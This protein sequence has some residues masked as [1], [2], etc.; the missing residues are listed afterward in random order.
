[1]GGS[2]EVRFDPLEDQ[3]L[4]DRCLA[5]DATAW[6]RLV[7]RHERLVFA[8]ARSYRLADSDLADVFQEVFAALVNGLPRLREPR[9]LVRWLS[10]TAQRIA[11]ATAL[12]RR[13]EQALWAGHPEEMPIPGPDEPVEA[14]LERIEEQAMVRLALTALPPRCQRLLLALYY[15]DP[16]PAYADIARRLGVPMGSIGPTRARCFERL[17]AALEALSSTP[18]GIRERPAPTFEPDTGKPEGFRMGVAGPDARLPL[19]GDSA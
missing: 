13:R 19:R 15:E 3:R 18:S 10:S 12:R 5:G 11:R 16:A 7:R 1:M 17:R 6:E 2:E 14:D 8:V 9:A 4:V